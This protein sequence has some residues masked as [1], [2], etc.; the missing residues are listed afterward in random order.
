MALEKPENFRMFFSYFV[1]TLTILFV[2]L[3]FYAL[4]LLPVY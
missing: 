2:F 1:A 4:E 3:F